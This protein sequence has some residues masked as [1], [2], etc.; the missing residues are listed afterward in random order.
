[1]LKV[2]NYDIE[3]GSCVGIN[4]INQIFFQYLVTCLKNRIEIHHLQIDKMK[5]LY[6]VDIKSYYIVQN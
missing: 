3:K 1:M 5:V 4:I 6:L 2:R